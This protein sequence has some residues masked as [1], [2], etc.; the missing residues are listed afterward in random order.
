MSA[1]QMS[2][3]LIVFDLD[4]TLVETAP[5]LVDT[6]NVILA[7]QDLPP[8][9]YDEARR[10]IGGGARK[11]VARALEADGRPTEGA[12]LDRLV[13]Q[14]LAHYSDH[15]ADRSH[16]FPHLTEAL[17][18]LAA[19]GSRFAVC[20]NK[21]EWLSVKLLDK[22]GLT[23]RFDAICGQDTFGV[24]KP[25]P[26]ALLGTIE[27]AGGRPDN[28][29][30]VGDSETDIATARAAKIPVVAVDFGY[31]EIPLTELSPDRLISSFAALPDAVRDLIAA[32]NSR[33]V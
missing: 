4:G 26:Y 32:R 24:M 28:A 1:L 25:D 30:M 21:L 10:L 16:A 5:D 23:K 18:R 29:I 13:A 11:M 6:L 19:Q 15:I 14:F 2:A 9:P 3:P 33:P 22:L 20:T 27:R 17:D 7:E 31:T 8:V 12:H